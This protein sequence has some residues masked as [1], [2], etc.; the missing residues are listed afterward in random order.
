MAEAKEPLG[1]A[2]QMCSEAF[3]NSEALGTAAG[4]ML[5]VLGK[6]W[7]EEVTAEKVGAIKA[8]MLTG[9]T[10]LASYSGR[11]YNFANGHSVS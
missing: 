3:Q 6:E 5:N 8:A 10:G 9:P 7:Y 11:W 2:K 1:K 4:E